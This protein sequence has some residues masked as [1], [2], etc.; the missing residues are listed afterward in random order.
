[1][2]VDFV[3]PFLFVL[4][5]NTLRIDFDLLICIWLVFQ[6]QQS[7]DVDTVVIISHLFVGVHFAEVG[8]SVGLVFLDG[9]VCCFE[10][11]F[12]LFHFVV[13]EADVGVGY[14]L[15]RFGILL[16]IEFIAL[17]GIFKLAC[18]E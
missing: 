5:N 11:L 15:V 4:L 8:L 13:A 6:K 10:W 7:V 18:P 1:M 16:N 12:V 9:A 17:D 2:I 3:Y 14:L